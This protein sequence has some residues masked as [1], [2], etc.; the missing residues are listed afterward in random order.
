MT[1][2]L[3]VPDICK[4]LVSGA[5]LS[6]NG[7]KITIESDNIVLTKNGVYVGKGYVKERLFK[8]NV[9]IVLPP[10]NSKIINGKSPVA[11]IV[12]LSN[13]WHERL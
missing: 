9:M 5:V 13:I 12:E 4:N 6:R 7:F 2:V 1:N 10:C 3:Y 11:Y 8:L